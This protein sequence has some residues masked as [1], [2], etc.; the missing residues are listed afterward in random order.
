MSSD[1]ED[2]LYFQS[3]VSFSGWRSAHPASAAAAASGACERR[4]GSGRRAVRPLF[5]QQ[6]FNKVIAAD[7]DACGR[8]LPSPPAVITPPT[9]SSPGSGAR[10]GAPSSS[11]SS[12]SFSSS[13]DRLYI[14]K[15]AAL[16]WPPS[17]SGALGWSGHHQYALHFAQW[18]ARSRCGEVVNEE[19]PRLL[20]K[21]Q[22]NGRLSVC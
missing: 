10:G 1:T 9:P 5:A 6:C 16:A 11:S 18:E 15:S 3:P 4:R 7:A 8:P 21:T 19:N 14:A 12:S 2:G 17:H 13:E 20:L 22:L